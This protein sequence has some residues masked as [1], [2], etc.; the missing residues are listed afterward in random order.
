MMW[1]ADAAFFA[2]K[3]ASRCKFEHSSSGKFG[4]NL[5]MGTSG[6]LDPASTVK[7]WYDEIAQYK[8]PN[9]GFSMATGHFTQVVW[10]GTTSVGCA[11]AMC[12]GQELFVCEYAPPGNWQG[13]YP[14]NVLPLGCK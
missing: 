1:N 6:A 3:W 4:E 5:A 10:V 12:D 9:G 2:Q 8:F 14:R 13:E 7:F 11:S